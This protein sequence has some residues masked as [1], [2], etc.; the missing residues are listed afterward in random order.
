LKISL[1]TATYNSA[2]T[3]ADTLRS[4]NEQTHADV[5]HIVVDGGSTD[6]TL[7]IVRAEGKRVTTLVSEPDR[8]I[9][10]A[11][12]KGLKL[13]TGDVVGMINSDDFFASPNV[14]ALVAAALADSELDAVYADL[15]FV[16]Q[17]DP[18]RVV[19]Y[20]RSSPFK[21]GLF[22]RGWIAPHPTLY[23][24]RGIFERFGGFDLAYP[25]AADT[26]LMARFFEVHRIRT[27]YIPEIFVRMRMGGAST[28][29][30]KGIAAQNREVWSA[31]RKNGLAGSMAGFAAHKLASRLRQFVTRPTSP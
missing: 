5:E 25:V 21:P 29:S 12:N 14:L 15:C 2:A 8:G 1:I 30:L 17:A 27:R 22:A 7:A 20:W 23:I 9:Y 28:R 16:R 24:R 31:L 3:V 13:A 6:A 10:D 19:R 18:S 4:V 11:M 26:E